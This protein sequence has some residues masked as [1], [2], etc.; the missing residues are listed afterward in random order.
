[1]VVTVDELQARVASSYADLALP[2]WAD[3]HPDRRSP[4]EEEYSRLTDPQRYRIVHARARVWAATLVDVL[5]VRRETLSPTPRSD[6][7]PEAFDRGVRLV[8][9][10]TGTL[11]LLLLERDVPTPTGDASLAVLSIGVVRPDLVVERQPDC[12]CD[13]CDCGSEDLLEAVDE[14]VRSVVRGPFV[15]LRGDGWHARWHPEGGSASGVAP[16]TEF[17]TLMDLCR[18][19]ARGESVALPRG[20]EAYVGRGWL[21]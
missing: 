17:R 15:V 11:P 12:G 18:R 1:M 16:R 14:T 19:L 13:A 21:S 5:G 10:R 20:T 7:G 3:P 4:A 6:A 2:S 9:R 8:P